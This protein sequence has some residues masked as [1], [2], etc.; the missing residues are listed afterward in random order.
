MA[1]TQI[2]KDVPSRDEAASPTDS[3]KDE[4]PN[5]RLLIVANRLP[6]TIKKLSDVVSQ[7]S[8]FG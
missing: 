5:F 6:I 7:K 4:G 1:P 2:D 3:G 8:G